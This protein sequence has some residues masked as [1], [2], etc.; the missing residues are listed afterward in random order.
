MQQVLTV[1]ADLL[2]QGSVRRAV[3]AVGVPLALSTT[4]VELGSTRS[5]LVCSSF[6]WAQGFQIE[7]SKEGPV[8]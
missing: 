6:C 2:G 4:P 1:L 8:Q 7:D 5:C 3:L